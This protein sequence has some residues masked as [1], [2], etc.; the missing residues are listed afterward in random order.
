[1]LYRFYQSN[2][3]TSGSLLSFVSC[4]NLICRR[5]HKRLRTC[6]L[7]L[8][9]KGIIEK[10]WIEM[11]CVSAV[12]Y[13]QEEFHCMYEQFIFIIYMAVMSQVHSYWLPGTGTYRGSKSTVQYICI[14]Y[15]C[16]ICYICTF[17]CTTSETSVGIKNKT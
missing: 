15:I 17:T 3:N 4:M 10:C 5:Y 14:C 16:Y 11:I 8:I 9:G 7:K 1:M 13:S 12:H 2:I 6:N